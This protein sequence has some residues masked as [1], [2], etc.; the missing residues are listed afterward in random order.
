[1]LF[2]ED[3]PAGEHLVVLGG[4][5]AIVPAHRVRSYVQRTCIRAKL[6]WYSNLHHGAILLDADKMRDVCKEIAKMI[7]V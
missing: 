6:L 5:D 7:L 3:L 2:V 1:M 4:L